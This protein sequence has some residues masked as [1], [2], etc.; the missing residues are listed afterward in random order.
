M[1]IELPIGHG[2]HA[3]DPEF[4]NLF[5]T[6]P[7][8]VPVS[9]ELAKNILE[10]DAKNKQLGTNVPI[11]LYINTPG[12]DLYSTWMLCDIIS[13]INT[14]VQT[15]GLGQVASGGF[16]IFMNGTPGRR[17]ATKN[18]QFMSHR[19][20]MAFEANHANIVSQ[21]PELD[22]IH[23]RIVSHYRKCTGLSIKDIEKYLL[24]EHDIW[25]T[26]DQCQTYGVCDLV[27]DT[28]GTPTKSKRRKVLHEK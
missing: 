19:Y 8:D 11:Q 28:T 9:T 26:A 18:T 2:P 6:G 7:I 22:R 5:L 21:R 16:L 17:I 27:V 14:P 4:V 3:S 20:S 15:V 23:D 13:T 25:L 12:G 10:I 1:R 24:S